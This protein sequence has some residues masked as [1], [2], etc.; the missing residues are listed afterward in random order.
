MQIPDRKLITLVNILDDPDFGS[1]AEWSDAYEA[2]VG[3]AK[4]PARW[5]RK[6]ITFRMAAKSLGH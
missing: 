4:P 6:E 5:L 1:R 3:A 2:F